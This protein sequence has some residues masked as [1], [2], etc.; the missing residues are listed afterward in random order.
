[1]I[2]SHLI[3]RLL[4]I[5]I[6]GTLFV[7]CVPQVAIPEQHPLSQETVSA[8]SIEVQQSPLLASRSCS[9]RFIAHD[10]PHITA[11]VVE[12]VPYFISNG[13]G[14]AVNDLDND[15][16]LDLVLANLFGPSHIFWNE[17][18]WQF[19]V[20]RVMGGEYTGCQSG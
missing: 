11:E 18:A 14:L 15:G 2:S 3:I 9:G 13:A 19:P 4:S 16:D 20:G 12:R 6:L 1:M 5:T 10:L 17:G 8:I 7:S